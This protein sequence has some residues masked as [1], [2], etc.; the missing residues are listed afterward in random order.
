MEDKE[1]KKRRFKIILIYFAAI[2][3]IGSVLYFFIKPNPTCHDGILNQGEKGIDCG[4]PCFPCIEEK[5]PVDLE[6]LGAEAV[7]YVDNKYDVAMRV[8]NDNSIFGASQ[9][10]LKVFLM[11]ESGEEIVSQKEE[12]GYYILPKEEKHF[13]VQGI[14]AE[15]KPSQVKI[16]IED[17][18]WEKF[19]QY[20]EPRLVVLRPVYTETPEEGGFS[21]ITGT[22]VNQSSND[23]ET[24]RVN[25]VLK[26]ENRKLLATNYQILDTI[27]ADEQRDFT[28]FFSSEFPGSVTNV[29]IEPETNVFDSENY[30]KTH[31]MIESWSLEDE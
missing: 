21:K 20:E 19:S 6:I 10:S 17:V 4:G 22:L 16:E 8:K 14:Q 30:V 15:S 5:K 18:V 13:I 24:I 7:H 27:R 11:N 29:I 9:I 25:V 28:M 31:G 12:D 23:F 1:R 2:L 3:V 26:D